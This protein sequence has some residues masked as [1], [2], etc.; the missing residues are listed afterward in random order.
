M[1]KAVSENDDL[2]LLSHTPPLCPRPCSPWPLCTFPKTLHETSSFDMKTV[3][4]RTGRG[5]LAKKAASGLPRVCRAMRQAPCPE[6][7][8]LKEP[9]EAC[10]DVMLWFDG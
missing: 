9:S 5:N 6:I 7:A 2:Q 1:Q 10:R 3:S 4:A 8:V